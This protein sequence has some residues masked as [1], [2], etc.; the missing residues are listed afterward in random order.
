MSRSARSQSL[1]YPFQIQNS[2]F[3]LRD[4]EYS[5]S[6]NSRFVP[7]S[8]ITVFKIWIIKIWPVNIKNSRFEFRSLEVNKKLIKA[9]QKS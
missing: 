5:R 4:I 9:S 2:R 6:R 1:L 8:D 3:G 7:R